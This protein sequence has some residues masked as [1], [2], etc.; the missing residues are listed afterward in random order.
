MLDDPKTGAHGTV[1][2]N[3]SILSSVVCTKRH[4]AGWS[5]DVQINRFSKLQQSDVIRS[6]QRPVVVLVDDWV[7]CQS[8]IFPEHPQIVL[9]LDQGPPIL[10]L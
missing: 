10:R 1:T 7:N 5:V 2:I 4:Q 8:H 3:A 6:G 9:F